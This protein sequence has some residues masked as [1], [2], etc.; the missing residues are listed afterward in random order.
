MRRIA[1]AMFDAPI[2]RVHRERIDHNAVT[3]PLIRGII[4]R[5]AFHAHE[6]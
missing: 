3:Q 1:P 4:S 2:M 6:R 5:Q